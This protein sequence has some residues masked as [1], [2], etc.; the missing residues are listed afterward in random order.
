MMILKRINNR[1]VILKSCFFSISLLIIFSLFSFWGLYWQD[2]YATVGMV[3]W[4]IVSAVYLISLISKRYIDIH[5][6]ENY[7]LIKEYYL[8]RSE[9]VIR[10]K[11]IVYYE[12]TGFSQ[13]KN[14]LAF[15]TKNSEI[16]F[17]VKYLTEADKSYLK[18]VFSKY[19]WV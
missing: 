4:V 1:N 9:K 16:K 17:S 10:S 5:V 13:N 6:Y 3:V 15:S 8:L 14:I 18:N 7:M 11:R 19:S 12:I 2:K